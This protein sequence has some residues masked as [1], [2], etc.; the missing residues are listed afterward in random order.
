M[1]VANIARQVGLSRQEVCNH[2]QMKQQPERTRIHRE[3]GSRLDPHQDYLI[4]RWNE[5]CRSAQLLYREI[6]EQ[7]FAG[8]DTAVGR[9]IAP[10]RRSKARRAVSSRPSPNL[11]P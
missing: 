7:G 8:S 2:L 4:R 9:F 11:T 6:K 3:S 10:W 5:G 1:D